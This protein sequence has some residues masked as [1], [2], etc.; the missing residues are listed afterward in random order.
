MQRPIT[1][2]VLRVSLLGPALLV[3]SFALGA[4][5]QEPAQKEVYDP[6]EYAR[7]RGV[8]SNTN[9]EATVPPACYTKT[10]GVSN[11]CW[12]CHTG[13]IAPN[14]LMDRELQVEYSFSQIALTNH[15]T[16]LFTDFGAQ[17]AGISDAEI[18]EWLRGDNY[19]PLRQALATA[20]EPAK[21]S[22]YRPDLDLEA[23]FDGDGFAQDG[24][25]WR[26]IRYKPFSG[27]FW[28]TNGS[29]D[30]VFVRLPE[31]FR[32]VDGVESREVEKANL[33]LLE[34]ALA[35]DHRVADRQAI[36]HPIEPLDER[37]L[38]S[39]LDGDGE[40]AA[41]TDVMR[42]L[43]SHYLGDASDVA[44]ERYVHPEGVEYLHTVRYVDLASPTGHAR[45]MKELRWS[46]KDLGLDAWA[47]QRAYEEEY[48][49]KEEGIVPYF[50]GGPEVGL[51][52]DFGWRLQ[53]F[54]EDSQGRLR[55]Q[56]D[57]EH[58]FC[59]GCHSAIGVTVDQTF[60]LPRK[61]PGLDGWR[62]QDLAGM[63]DAPQRGHER[64]EVLT[65]LERV[66]GGDEFRSNDE[67]LARFFTA[68]G[69]VRAE[70][71]LR[72]APGG[73]A[74]LRTLVMPSERRALELAKAYLVLVRLQR[75][76]HGRDA[77]LAPVTNVHATI[78][79]GD[80]ALSESGLLFHDGSLWLDWDWRLPSPSEVQSI[81]Q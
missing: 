17:R 37:A 51:T 11:P 6:L 10:D 65:Y 24:S 56:S 73:E 26:A 5:A 15:W 48:N 61:A 69:N 32:T 34:V 67:M 62:Y 60:T 47:M 27:T 8:P 40:L 16:N 55:L 44:I 68:E 39:D 46:R 41:A 13:G 21:F 54:I 53:G 28:P 31:R 64:P 25:G 77:L 78:E 33:T 35:A 38:A 9:W 3:G 49:Q 76:E 63:Q 12:V 14:D 45:R 80:T 75:F 52:N 1:S 30:D 42:G 71:V 7:T 4:F 58:R 72:A 22:G 43:P 36:V 18:S 19:T 70:N 23:G 29:I 59:M 79:N 20:I 66:R 50:T 74:D 81:P 2:A 57:E